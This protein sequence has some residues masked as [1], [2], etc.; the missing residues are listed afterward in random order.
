MR[1]LRKISM[2]SV[3]VLL[4]LLCAPHVLSE[5]KRISVFVGIPP[6]AYF[7]E[8]IAGD[9][10][11]L[12]TLM[13]A[14]QNPVTYEPRPQQLKRLYDADIFFQSGVPFEESWFKNNLHLKE[15][16]KVVACCEEFTLIEHAHEHDGH[17]HEFDPHYWTSPVHAEVIAKIVYQELLAYLPNHKVQLQNNYEGLL[18]ELSNLNNY[19][20]EQLA[21][22]KQRSFMISHPAWGYFAKDYGLQQISLEKNGKSIRARQIIQHI[23]LA[24]K[25][26]MR[27]VFSQP[28]FNQEAA[29]LIAKGAA[30]EVIELDPMHSDYINNLYQVTDHIV[31]GLK[32]K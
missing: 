4:L 17:N 11:E 29:E 12:H 20:E 8:R 13:P 2:K 10:V 14:S 31:N 27:A 16:L 28:Q 22:L 1:L 26:N 25:L 19:I 18:K 7:V 6:Q 24:R 3:I 32:H 23:D 30:I 21:D 9:L 5:E 15:T